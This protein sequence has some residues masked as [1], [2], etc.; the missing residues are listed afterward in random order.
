MK[1]EVKRMELEMKR[2][3]WSLSCKEARREEGKRRR[4]ARYK[5]P[6]I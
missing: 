4:G 1:N 6:N 5:Y 2:D 3:M